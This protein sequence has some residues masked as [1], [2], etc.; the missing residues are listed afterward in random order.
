[1]KGTSGQTRGLD[2]VCGVSL[3]SHLV[4]EMGASIKRTPT[5]GT[6]V[7]AGFGRCFSHSC[8]SVGFNG[9]LGLSG[10]VVLTCIVWDMNI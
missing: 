1:M 6:A 7:V 9:Q 8:T 2:K 10:V 5:T 3:T 4:D